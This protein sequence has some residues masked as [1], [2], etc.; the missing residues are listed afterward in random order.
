MKDLLL[1]LYDWLAANDF[2]TLLE[3]LRNLDW[4]YILRNFYT[5]LIVAPILMLTIVTKSYKILV[6]FTSFVL[7]LLLLQY[8][9]PPMGEKIPLND[10][11]TFLGGSFVL[12]SVNLYFLFI[13]E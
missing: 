1:R 4:H 6:A 10:L 13:K 5:W 12:V 11:L 3:T 9:L 2:P 7:F 8:T